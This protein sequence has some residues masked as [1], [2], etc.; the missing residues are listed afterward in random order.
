MYFLPGKSES[1]IHTYSQIRSAHVCENACTIN[2]FRRISLFMCMCVCM[3]VMFSLAQDFFS[4]SSAGHMDAL[5]THFSF[6]A[7]VLNCPVYSG[8]DLLQNRSFTPGSLLSASI[9]HCRLAHSVRDALQGIAHAPRAQAPR[10]PRTACS[11]DYTCLHPALRAA[12]FVAI[13]DDSVCCF[14]YFLVVLFHNSDTDIES[15]Y[16]K[17]KPPPIVILSQR[18]DSEAPAKDPFYCST[19]N[20]FP[21]GSMTDMIE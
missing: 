16:T 5:K 13:Q 9:R 4:A 7:A 1:H 17:G 10:A 8:T 18:N 6:G 14:L 20:M 12:A 19:V 15:R 2:A 3:Y 21:C 11:C